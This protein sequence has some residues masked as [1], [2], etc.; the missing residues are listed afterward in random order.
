MAV[1]ILMPKWGLTMKE[2]TV[3][4][5]LKAIGDTVTKGENLLE[6]ETSK[7]TNTVES[8]GD[9]T[10]HQIVVPEGETVPVMTILGV[11]A[12]EGETPEPRQAVVIA[13][14]GEE[15][16][17]PA[18]VAEKEKPKKSGFVPASP[19]ARRLAKDWGIDLADVPATGP[20]GRVVEQDVRDYK[21]KLD[22][23]P[24]AP[25]R[26]AAAVYASD[27]AFEA[28]KRAGIDIS[29]V[30]GTG[31]G[32]KITKA[33]VLKAVH[34]SAAHLQ[35]GRLIPGTVIPMDGMRKVIADNMMASL[36]NAAQL[37]VFVEA[38][39]TPMVELRDK[40]RK[41]HADTDLPRVSYND[42]IA[43]AVCR[44]LKDHPIM[45]SCLTDAGIEL[46]GNVNLGIAV[47]LEDGLVVP[48]VKMADVLGL[49]DIAVRIR[50]LAKKAR[51]NELGMDEIQGGTF[52][53]TNVSM[54]GV[55]GFTPILNPPE[56]GILGVGR[57]REKPGVHN[58]QICIRTMMTLSLTFD[59]RV[60]DGA[61]AMSFLR[62]LADYLEDPLTLL[63]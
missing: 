56:T 36:H 16:S 5:W 43:Y 17:G 11:L 61:P 23:T 47:A 15:S 40:L 58:G 18:P 63:G 13:Q 50:E 28:A 37:T 48:N 57:T 31:V 26:T 12:E 27:S 14:E 3:S 19:L 10:L 33:D 8:P 22:A 54:I 35:T 49:M 1:E 62:T 7:I 25:V 24:A 39:V 21:D 29:L 41:K 60:V 9:G 4:K 45:N 42:I 30:P 44:A 51:N 55:D 46:A 34:P 38:D 59:H 2:G 6:V 20:K 32:A 52:T 53:I